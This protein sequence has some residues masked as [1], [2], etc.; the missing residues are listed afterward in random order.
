MDRP[1]HPR[2]TS[3]T[4]RAVS[5]HRY[6]ALPTLQASLQMLTRLQPP[7]STSRTPTRSR[8]S[9]PPFPSG[10]RSSPSFSPR[11]ERAV[12][13]VLLLAAD[14]RTLQRSSQA[15]RIPSRPIST[16]TSRERLDRGV[17][18]D[19]RVLSEGLAMREALYPVYI[20]SG[21]NALFDEDC[22]ERWLA[23][24]ARGPTSKSPPRR[25]FS[26]TS[27]TPT[28]SLPQKAHGEH[29][30]ASSEQPS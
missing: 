12:A 20:R 28:T 14:L 16:T 9:E 4:T 3:G 13:D 8:S 7:S 10:H 21:E 6:V 11:F 23:L 27:H 2:A 1:S 30:S 25:F 5:A 15:R 24:A 19:V 18:R 29:Q 26:L 17:R 22:L